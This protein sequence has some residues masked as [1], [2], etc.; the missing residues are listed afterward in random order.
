MPDPGRLVLVAGSDA[1]AGGADRE[2]SE[3]HLRR[4]VEQHVVRH[5]QVRRA[6]DAQAVDRDPALLQG[7]ELAAQHPGVDDGPVADDAEL[8]RVEDPRRDQVQLERLAVAH[9]R[10]P[11]VVAAL[12]PHHHVAALGEQVDD[13]ALALVA[14]L[15]ADDHCRGHRVDLS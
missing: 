7:V 14:P 3:P 1:A 8:A 15:G 5:D 2:P 13:L 10:V 6:R 11:G 12:E 4:P 9:D